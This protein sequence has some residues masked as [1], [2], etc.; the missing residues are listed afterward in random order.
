MYFCVFERDAMSESAEDVRTVTML[1]TKTDVIRALPL[2]PKNIPPR[3]HFHPNNSIMHFT[4]R[5]S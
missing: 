5:I 3:Q 1:I 2:D 4:P